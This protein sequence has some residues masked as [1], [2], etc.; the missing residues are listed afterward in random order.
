MLSFSGNPPTIIYVGDP[1]CSWCYGVSKELETLK[2]NYEDSFS[3]EIV[4]GG[5]RPYNTETMLDLKSFLTHHWEDVSARSGQTFNYEVLNNPSITYDTEPPSRALIIV[6]ELA[7]AQAFT[8][9]HHIQKS[10]YLDNKNMH[11]ASAYYDALSL[12]SIDTETF[13][14]KFNAQTYKEKVKEDFLKAQALGV[15]SFP[16][17]LIEINGKIEVLSSGYFTAADMAKKLDMIV[18]KK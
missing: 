14:K 17:L 10:F 16:T 5:L 4:M 7:P 9:F 15:R 8:F 2:D 13:T 18:S 6:R 12:T 11:E 1:M 3:F